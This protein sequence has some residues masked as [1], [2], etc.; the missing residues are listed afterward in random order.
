MYGPVL[1]HH[2]ANLHQCLSVLLSV[3]IRGKVLIEESSRC[4]S[5]T[6]GL[7]GCLALTAHLLDFASLPKL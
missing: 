7:P 1:R 4:I 2:I 6:A 3:F 5:A